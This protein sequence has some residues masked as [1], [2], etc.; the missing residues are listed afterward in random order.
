MDLNSYYTK[1][2][3]HETAIE[4]EYPIV[5]SHATGDGGIAGRMTEVT[6]RIAARLIVEGMAR[7]ANVIE[8]KSFKDA[9]QQA[10]QMAEDMAANARLQLAA[11]AAA[12]V[13]KLTQAAAAKVM[14]TSKE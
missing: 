10:K 4:D 11:M 9:K 13:Q 12:E 1:M 3:E 5:V 6:K 8:A 14:A 2:R 7:L